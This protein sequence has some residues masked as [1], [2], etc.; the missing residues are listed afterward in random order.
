MLFAALAV[1]VFGLLPRLGGLAHD[2]AAL[3]YARAA[4]VAAAVL[5]QAASLAWYALVY[6]RVLA[7]LGAWARVRHGVPA[8]T[9]IEAIGQTS[10]V[11][12]LALLVLFGAGFAMTAGRQKLPAIGP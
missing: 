5:A 9:T 11:S 8:A 6:R 2:A 7:S 1:S 4:F 12:A 3:W 10:L